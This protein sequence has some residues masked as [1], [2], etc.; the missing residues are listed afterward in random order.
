MPHFYQHWQSCMHLFKYLFLVFVTFVFISPVWSDNKTS[1]VPTPKLVLQITVD[2]LRGDL[3][4][5]Y[6]ERFDQGGFNYLLKGVVFKNAHYQHANTE[7]IVG[8]ATLA[9]GAHPSVHGMTGNVWFDSKSGELAYNIEDP[10]HPLL[11]TRD[12][13]SKGDQV[14]PAQK[15]ARSKGRSP[16][17]ILA[18]TF[19]DRLKAYTG[20]RSKV[21]A[22]SG[23]DRSAV[24]MAG[25][26]GK[27]FWMS[28]NNGDF[29][30][31][32][33]YYDDYPDW[34]KQWNAK[35]QVEKVGNK[36]WELLHKKSSY[37]LGHQD[38]RIYETDLRGY[39]RVFPH[40]FAEPGSSILPTQVLVSPFGDR[41]TSDFARAIIINEKLGQD[42]IPDYLSISFSG[43]DAVNH[44]FGPSSLENEDMV[45]QLDQTLQ[46]LFAFI[47]DIVGL[48]N[49]LIVL[50]ADHGM[51][52][53]PEYMHEL[54]YSAG[55][56]FSNDL[57]KAINQFG[58][59]QFGVDEIVK[60]YFRPYLYLDDEKI[61]AAKQDI[62]K[63]RK[64][65]AEY[66]V[67][68]RGVAIAISRDALQ[69]VIT[70]EPLI[71][72]QNNFHPDRSGDIYIV[73]KPY[74]FNYDK[75]PIAAMHGSPWS[76]DTH[77][78]I[79]FAGRQLN[80]QIIYRR[81]HPT[82]VAPSLS[83]YLGM[84]PPGSAQGKVLPELFMD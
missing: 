20:G 34:V 72:I 81:V 40:P 74:W 59:K 83:A 37:L 6:R 22:V 45:L 76:Y 25:Q 57:I 39:G 44:F 51:P 77:V 65:I 62:K 10:N 36:Q 33:Y 53:M 23:K 47:D 70:T 55:R 30:T 38:D 84:S 8:H 15:L 1:Q 12:E 56:I 80:N 79:I 48:E 50:S 35:R 49:T 68:L 31:S 4:D 61:N 41:I 43:V 2:G 7:T 32:S 46:E 19:A 24:S 67:Q 58:S 28:T 17:V 66:L 60:F 69:E 21:F 13:E 9:T 11:P 52:E 63:V 26:V 71:K 64:D 78:P 27:A 54:G 82:D 42:A 5:R 18:E 29:V 75:G 16:R 3:I 14:D 73:Q